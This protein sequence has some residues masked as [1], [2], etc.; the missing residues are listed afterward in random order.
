MSI[1]NL[2]Y[3]SYNYLTNLAS[4]NANEVNTDILTKSDPDITDLQFDML[5]GINTNETIQ[6]QI[7]GIIAGLETVGY[8][9]VFWS[10]ADQTNAGATSV[11]LMTVNNSDPNNNQV[12]IG[13][14][15]SQIKVLNAGTY[16]IQFSAQFDKSDGGKDTVDVWFVKNGVNI[17]DSN[18]LFSL[19][20][21]NDKLI[22]A[23]NLIVPLSANDYIQL[24]WH[25]ADTALFLH[26]DVAGT[27]PTR[28]AVPSVIITVQQ[29]T[30]IV[31]GPTGAIGPTGPTGP[32][33]IGPTGPAGGP[34]GPTGPTG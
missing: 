25:S 33:A 18:S 3:T 10:N 29:V 4:V 20:G 17:P 27:S 12:Q 11:N 26:H 5:E 24:A 23:L 22:A 13:A 1:S 7:D 15:S 31:A 6:Q 2:D 16:N 21:N 19:E 14:T 34:T 32:T 28:P 30:N 9:G 8:W